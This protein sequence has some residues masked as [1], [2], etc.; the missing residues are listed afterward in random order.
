[1]RGGEFLRAGRERDDSAPRHAV[2][3]EKGKWGVAL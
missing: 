3:A 2:A 1:M